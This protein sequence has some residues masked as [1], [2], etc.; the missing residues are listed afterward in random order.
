L[1][2]SRY[3]DLAWNGCFR[4]GGVDLTRLLIDKARSAGL[5]PR[6][7]A[8]VR[9]LDMGCGEGEAVCELV[10]QGFDAVGIDRSQTLIARGLERN[11]TVPIQAADVLN[12]P[13]RL[14]FFHGILG[15]CVFSLFSEPDFL[16]VCRQF[17]FPR[18]VL[19]LSDIFSPGESFQ[20]Q[21]M[22]VRSRDHLQSALSDGG[23]DLVAVTDCSDLLTVFYA[24]KIL[25][26][27]LQGSDFRN[28]PKI[29][30]CALVARLRLSQA[31]PGRNDS[32]D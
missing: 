1:N 22:A 24:Q 2:S 6:A 4:P 16:R 9:I 10:R 23:F 5:L 21:G 19:M 32:A 3:E 15:E 12:L 11:P 28:I 8:G 20:W 13:S 14:G 18:G 27:A 25:D 7:A 30:Y 17:L 29:G 26:G 31:I